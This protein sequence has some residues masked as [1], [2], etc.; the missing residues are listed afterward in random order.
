MADTEYC[1]SL[2]SYVSG[3]SAWV[4]VVKPSAADKEV[5]DSFPLR[6]YHISC[7]K[8]DFNVYG[9]IA[10]QLN[11]VGFI[12]QQIQSLSDVSWP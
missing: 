7:D 8:S 9:Y 1:D 6:I 11:K 2:E 4:S 5:F 10:S 12:S 3:F